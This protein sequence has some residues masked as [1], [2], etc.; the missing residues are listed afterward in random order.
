MST[1]IGTIKIYGSYGYIDVSKIESTDVGLCKDCN[2]C[3][4]VKDCN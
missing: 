3:V 4:I 2:E 1:D